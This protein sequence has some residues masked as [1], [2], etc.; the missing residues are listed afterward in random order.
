MN[1]LEG[2]PFAPGNTTGPLPVKRANPIPLRS[3]K[4]MGTDKGTDIWLLTLSDLLMLLVICFVILF[5]GALQKQKEVANSTARME[6]RKAQLE[7]QASAMNANPSLTTTSASVEKALATMLSREEGQQGIIVERIADRVILTF[8][9]R[10]VFDPGQ[11]ELKADA[12]MTP[13]QG[14]ILY[15]GAELSHRRGAGSHRRPTH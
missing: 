1:N 15:H 12:Q 3:P 5:A 2:W 4:T 13:G 11:V 14:G 7:K 8:P 10:I 6:A 9:E